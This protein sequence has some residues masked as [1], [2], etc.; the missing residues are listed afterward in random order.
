[1]QTGVQGVQD[2]RETSDAQY[3]DNQI[4]A[5][6]TMESARRLAGSGSGTS[7]EAAHTT[8]MAEIAEE[9][10]A[11]A[12]RLAADI[13][14]AEQIATIQG[15]RKEADKLIATARRKAE[16]DNAEQQAEEIEANT[17]KQLADI[18]EVKR[19]NEEAYRIASTRDA[20]NAN[21]VQR[22]LEG[23]VRQNQLAVHGGSMTG[24]SAAEA[25]YDAR[26][27]QRS[28]YLNLKPPSCTC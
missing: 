21:K 6:A 18:A 23:L 22:Q 25:E 26:M 13:A 16:H 27:P 24:A 14:D 8:R 10:K 15:N 28:A 12:D 11:T 17:D 2:H 4:V 3:S 19:A 20:A 7:A 9:R 5:R 1:M